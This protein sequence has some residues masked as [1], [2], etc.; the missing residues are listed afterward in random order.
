VQVSGIVPILL[1]IILQE[2]QSQKRSPGKEQAAAK[3]AARPQLPPAPAGAA[4][5]E[6][7]AARLRTAESGDPVLLPLP[8][9]STLFPDARFF[10]FHRP[11][12]EKRENRSRG[13]EE[14]AE[15]GIAFSLA[16]RHLGRLFFTL[17]RRA[18]TINI[19]CYAE[20]EETAAR[21]ASRSAELQRQLQSAGF[22]RVIFRCTVLDRSPA[23]RQPA[24]ASPSLLDRKV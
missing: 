1:N 6:T 9:K 21:L 16:T 24:F 4:G 17:A 18:E 23:G 19:A 22:A 5:E 8:L 20:R 10:I 2:Q 11:Q 7:A 3:P 13:G 15:T 14:A 12:D